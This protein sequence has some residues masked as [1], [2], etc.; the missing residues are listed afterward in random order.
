MEPAKESIPLTEKQRYWLKHITTAQSQN[1]SLSQYARQH[2]L[3]PK[4]LYNWHWLLKS[5]GIM[6]HTAVR[7]FVPVVHPQLK[8][9]HEILS[10]GHAHLRIVFASGTEVEIKIDTAQLREV[11]IAVKAL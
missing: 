6:N 4:A 5:K 10:V 2:D 7:S 8:S 1:L 11:L 3:S 9:R